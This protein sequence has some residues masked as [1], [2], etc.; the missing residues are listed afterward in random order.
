MEDI[1]K[2]IEALEEE[3]NSKGEEDIQEPKEETPEVPIE[4]VED[5]DSQEGVE[6]VSEIPKGKEKDYGL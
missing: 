4:V 5:S 1:D 6:V 3:V 2:E